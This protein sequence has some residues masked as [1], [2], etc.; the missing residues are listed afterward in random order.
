MNPLIICVVTTGVGRP[1]ESNLGSRHQSVH[2]VVGR[3]FEERS[4]RIFDLAIAMAETRL[5][6]CLFL[7]RP[8]PEKTTEQLIELAALSKAIEMPEG[9]FLDFPQKET[10]FWRR[11]YKDPK[12]A[13]RRAISHR[14]LHPARFHRR[15]MA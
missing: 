9:L 15:Y 6:T 12:L 3:G 13:R 5:E 11:I 4:M 1:M 14:V 10:L 8:D 7:E 2:F